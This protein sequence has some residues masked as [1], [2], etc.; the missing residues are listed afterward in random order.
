MNGSRRTTATVDKSGERFPLES[1]VGNG[2]LG[3][4]AEEARP[5]AFTDEA[6]ALR[7]AEQHA[8]RLRYVEVWG[9]WLTWDGTRWQF[10]DTLAA[11][12]LVRATCRIASAE[13][14]REN[15]A[16]TLA[17]AKTVAAVER[18]ARSDRRLAATVDQW[19]VDSWL[20]NTPGGIVDL[21]SGKK[22]AHRADAYMT[23]ITAVA[24]QEGP[25]PVWEAFLRRV[26]GGDDKLVPFLRR[27]AG[28]SL[29]GSTQAHA[30]FFIHGAGAN[31][32]STFINTLIGCL[33]EY[34]RT[35]PIE[36]FI[37]SAQDRHPT[38]LAGLKGARLVTAVETEESRGWNESKI[39]TL[40]GGDKI[41]ARLMR[42]DFF[43]FVPQFKLLFAGNHKPRLQSVD[44][45]IRRRIHLIPFTVTIPPA[46]RDEALGERLRA[47]W[48]GILA[49]A[50]AGC[51]EWQEHGLAPPEAVTAATGSYFEAEDAI[52]AWIDERCHRRPNAWESSSRLFSS[53]RAW[54][55]K[56][57]ESA[58][59]MKRFVQCLEN[60]GFKWR[61]QANGRGFDGLALLPSGEAG[62]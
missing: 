23:K 14:N 2:R 61:R 18:L 31:G 57:G 29:T 8:G 48:P 5:P 10:D 15:V 3:T 9:R 26:T 35:A 33:G 4:D 49:W 56:V 50:I 24:P 34:H 22:F 39:K 55:D 43:E 19:D 11:Y 59:S 60:R 45:A 7:F 30:L 17:S 46:E 16:T 21:R 13:C 52:A 58:G 44:E 47:E 1:L 51:L 53:W 38:D 62:R 42:Q 40:T 12:D 25:T 20:L 28:Y 41:A 6:L 36:T 54:A 32:K 37:A 27:M